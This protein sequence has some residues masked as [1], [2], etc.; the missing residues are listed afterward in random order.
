M[1][2]MGMEK[3]W[4]KKERERLQVLLNTVVENDERKREEGVQMKCVGTVM[5]W[6]EDMTRTT[7]VIEKVSGKIV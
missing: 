5:E 4:R 6:I 1:K 2:K 7:G 3:E